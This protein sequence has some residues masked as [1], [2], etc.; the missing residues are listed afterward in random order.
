VECRQLGFLYQNHSSGKPWLHI[1]CQTLV[2]SWPLIT[3][4]KLLQ[5][6][7]VVFAEEE[8]IDAVARHNF[9]AIGK[10]MS[11]WLSQ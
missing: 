7:H 6:S 9:L 11:K 5:E 8:D 10:T 1:S 4:P 2:K 3:K